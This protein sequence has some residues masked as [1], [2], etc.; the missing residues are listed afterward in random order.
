MKFNL[1]RSTA[2]LTLKQSLR[3]CNTKAKGQADS[4]FL[5]QPSNDVLYV[6][7]LNETAEQNIVLPCTDLEYTQDESFSA[8][9]QAL[10]EFLT[11]FPDEDIRCVYDESESQLMIGNK[12]TR[13]AFP[14]G[15]GADFVPFN[16]QPQGKSIEVSAEALKSALKSAAFAASHDST[17]APLTAV[18]VKITGTE[19]LAEAC[20]TLRIS[21]HTLDIS[22]IGAD[23]VEL[24]IPHET[25]EVL[26]NLFEDVSTVTIN[27][28]ARHVRFEWG[29]TMFTSTLENSIG[30]AYPEL[31]KFMKGKELGSVKISKANLARS[32]KLAALVAKDSYVTI[33]IKPLEADSTGGGLIIS[34]KEDDRGMSQ[35]TLIVQE[36]EGEAEVNVAH[37]F[38]SKAIDSASEAW[39][40]LAF[41]EV[42]ADTVA[43][44]LIDGEFEHLFF[45]AFPNKSDDVESNE[46]ED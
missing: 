15:S 44:V 36:Q 3:T 25:A 27:P 5:F 34:T 1:T 4:E 40:S 31:S 6:T 10:V 29:E 38:I 41:R 13:F 16:Y 21:R 46:E 37:R 14:T 23:N 8:P 7:S 43:L 2:L 12:K 42:R 11:Q 22:D 32:L 26:T 18:H 24:L 17:Q 28:G 39:I 19:L 35:D 45:P 20:D 33:A 30:K 9:G